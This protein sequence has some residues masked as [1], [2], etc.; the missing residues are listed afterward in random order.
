VNRN[1]VVELLAF[2]VLP[3]IKTCGHEVNYNE[4]HDDLIPLNEDMI[5]SIIGTLQ[6]H[7][8]CL[9]LS[10]DDVGRHDGTDTRLPEC[11]DVTMIA[12]YLPENATKTNM[13]SDFCVY[14]NACRNR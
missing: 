9:G 12:G 2:A 13:V 11:S 1:E 3:H 5:S 4:L 7:Y 10:C 8:N 14:L 6:S